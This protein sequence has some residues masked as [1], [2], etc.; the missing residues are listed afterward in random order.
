[1]LK[2]KVKKGLME[3][4]R[5]TIESINFGADLNLSEYQPISDFLRTLQFKK[6]R[7]LN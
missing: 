2:K 7:I 6:K 4:E 3:W 1:M 5:E